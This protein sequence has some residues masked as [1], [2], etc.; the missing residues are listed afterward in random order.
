MILTLNAGSSSLK[1]ALYERAGAALRRILGGRIESLDGQPRFVAS[2][3]HGRALSV[4][5]FSGRDHE[6]AI[7]ALLD[8]LHARDPD[9]R[10]SAV[11]HRVVHG[12]AGFSAPV[13]V[14][15]DILAR[16]RALIP[17][18]PLHMPHNLAAM[19]I[20]R[21]RVPRVAQIA[22]FDTA[23]HHDLPA[24]ERELAVPRPWREH[25]A[26][27]YGF[28]GLSY[29]YI[30]GVLPRHLGALADGRVIVAH[31]GHGASLCA[32]RERRSRATTMGLTP[33]DGIPMATRPGALDPGVVT[34]AMREL[35]LSV[36]ETDAQLND[37]AG[38]LGLSGISGDTRELLASDEPR[39]AF[40]IDYFAHRVAREIASLAGAIGG[41]DALVFTAGIGEHSAPIRAAICAAAG[42]L[43][44]ELDDQA[45]RAAK[46]HLDAPS[47]R[48]RVLRLA[49]D[50][51]LV[52]ARAARRLTEARD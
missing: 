17:L 36:A 15:D 3:A 2:D 52:I 26:R 11:G 24:L 39:A 23:F 8:W 50:E 1:F 21:R 9:Q 25:G 40:A 27:R 42:W 10:I 22:C 49:T 44:I 14:D 16:L 38:L 32:L 34:W 19:E 33:L 5:P 29:E 47:S 7:G 20:L 13:V 46:T 18:A 12:G 48:V 4:P 6:A 30:A 37:R 28:H 43:G 35:G 31:L 51:E 45:N 41:L